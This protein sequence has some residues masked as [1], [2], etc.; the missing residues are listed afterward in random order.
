MHGDGAGTI[1]EELVLLAVTMTLLCRWVFGTRGV[2]KGAQRPDYG[3]LSPAL[4]TDT[5]APAE[6]AQEVLA[7]AGIRSTVAPAGH[8]FTASGYPWPA[9]A[10]VVLVFPGDLAAAEQVLGSARS[11]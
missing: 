10:Q 1:A 11:L 7:A 4:R 2:R 9:T 8:G 3:I 5:L 6:Q